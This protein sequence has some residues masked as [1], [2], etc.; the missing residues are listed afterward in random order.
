MD[1]QNLSETLSKVQKYTKNLKVTLTSSSIKNNKPLIQHL[2]N[3][4][5]TICPISTSS[6][7]CPIVNS[8]PSPCTHHD[9]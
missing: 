9:T 4:P 8:D 2:N 1:K 5:K 7:T 3:G 6:M